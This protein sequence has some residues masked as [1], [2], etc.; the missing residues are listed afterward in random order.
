MVKKTYQIGNIENKI[1]K[2]NSASS[3]YNNDNCKN[4]IENINKESI[5]EETF[6][7][8]QNDHMSLINK[9]F[10]NDLEK[11]SKNAVS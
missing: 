5:N 7:N 8:S 2:T 6:N 10:E 1:S 9:T 4:Y 3:V 11:L